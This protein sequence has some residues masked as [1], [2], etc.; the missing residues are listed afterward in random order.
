ME[1]YDKNGNGTIEFDEFK[2]IVSIGTL[3]I[4]TYHR[5]LTHLMM[6]V[7]ISARTSF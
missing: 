6:D 1:V 2:S 5:L 4:Q 3:G 7:A